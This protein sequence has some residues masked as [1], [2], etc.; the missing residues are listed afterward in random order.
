MSA[1]GFML[2]AVGVLAT[3]VQS[4]LALPAG[5]IFTGQT[6]RGATVRL[7]IHF[8]TGLPGPPRPGNLGRRVRHQHFRVYEWTFEG[9]PVRCGGRWRTG[10]FRITGKEFVWNRYGDRDGLGGG[11]VSVGRHGHRYVEGTR[12][13]LLSRRRP[14]RLRRH[15]KGSVRVHGWVPL[16]GGGQA[17]CDSGHLRW[18]A[19]AP[20]P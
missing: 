19:A 1:V 15:A 14:F 8:R 9:V 7:R 4:V 3:S 6:Q 5:K 12:G 16:V 18:T 11:A 20:R 13:R 2:L 10:R 17:K